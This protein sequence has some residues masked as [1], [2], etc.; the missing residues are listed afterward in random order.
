MNIREC[1]ALLREHD[2]FL[3]VTHHRPDGDT[4]GSAAA[5][6]RGLRQIGKT[7]YLFPNVQTTETY[8]PFVEPYLAPEGFE[9]A[10]VI[11]T[12]VATEKMFA[13]GFTGKVDM[14]IDHHPTNSGYAVHTL[15]V[16]EKAAAGEVIMEI[17][18]ELCGKLDPEM[19]S[20]LYIA[21]S[22]DTGC[23][24][25]SNTTAAAHRAA[26]DLIEAGAALEKINK[27]LFRTASAARLQLEAM[28]FSNLRRFRDGQIN[29][30]VVTL[31]MMREAG[32]S[33]DDCD[34][35]AGLPGKIAGNKISVTIRELAPG[36]CK[37]SVRSGMEV[38]AAAV[39]AIYGGGGHKMA[40][41]CELEATP[42]EA[43]EKMLQAIE[44]VWK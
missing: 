25:Y 23:F 32:T 21:V 10:Y 28:I 9:P 18:L 38:D 1:A 40:A 44:E 43:V 2:D 13:K 7:A 26:A 29:M 31:D 41:G 35:L 8:M 22:T 4:L 24:E 34:D 14:A 39:C 27:L 12:D 33:D 19:A 42:D 37:V 11:A 17:L 36:H 6:C 30:A 3:L 15:T 20:L 16:P 5:L